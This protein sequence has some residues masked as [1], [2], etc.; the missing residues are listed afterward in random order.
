MTLS[1][2]TPKQTKKGM[3]AHGLGAVML[4]DQDLK[5]TRLFGVENTNASV[6]PPGIS[7]LPIPTTFLADAMGIIRW[8]DQTDDY[9]ERSEP[10]RV[11]A[12]VAKAIP[13]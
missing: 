6:R 5:V 2:D 8:V 11:M 4:S 1:T 7:A 9:T 10:G 3:S 12:A 13:A